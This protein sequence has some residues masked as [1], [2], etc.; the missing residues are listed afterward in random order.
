MSIGR[1]GFIK[2]A[3]LAA[4]AAA[5]PLP[6]VAAPPKP[7]RDTQAAQYPVNRAPLQPAAFLR[8]PPGSVTPGGW[9]ATQ[10]DHQVDGLNGRYQDTSHFLVFN[11]TGWVDPSLATGWEEVPYWLRGYGDLGYLTGDSRVRSSTEQWI[12]RS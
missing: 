5:L 12:R 3:L 7:P 1:R 11:Q 4:G 2:G 10:L 6:A 8:L 9:L